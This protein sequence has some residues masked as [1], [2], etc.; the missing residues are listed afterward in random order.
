MTFA[1]SWNQIIKKNLNYSLGDDDILNI[2]DGKVKIIS[3][4]DLHNFETID[5][6]LEPYGAVIILY[7]QTKL[8]GHWVSVIKQPKNVIEIFGSYGL[9]ID[10]QLEF[11]TYNQK[12]HGGKAQ[13]HLT[14]LINK[15][16]YKK[17][18]NSHQLQSYN[19]QVSTC[20]RYASLR[21]RFRDLPLDFF[22]K[23]FTNSSGLDN[24]EWATALT[25]LFS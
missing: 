18:Y 17:I 5:Q 9:K 10:E 20:G 6:L 7:Q 8:I 23:L 12:L 19:N 11:S 13:P 25:L 16:G 15:S 4:E 24:D 22:V 14:N 3:Y 2:C 21:V 1:N